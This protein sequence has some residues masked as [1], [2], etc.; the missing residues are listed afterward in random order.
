MK[1]AS[2]SAGF[3]SGSSERPDDTRPSLLARSSNRAMPSS[4][5]QR[6]VFFFHRSMAS[7]ARAR[8]GGGGMGWDEKKKKKKKEVERMMR[9]DEMRMMR[10]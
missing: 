2:S 9:R 4:V 3:S 8:G 7:R 10:R 1:A 5:P 6:A